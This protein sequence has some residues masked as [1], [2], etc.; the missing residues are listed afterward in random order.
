MRH[1]R[2]VDSRKVW[3]VEPELAT[4]RRRVHYVILEGGR[5]RSAKSTEKGVHRST[6][7]DGCSSS[8]CPASWDE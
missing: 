6:A 3:K 2:Q 5:S 8:V 1:P 4:F 7:K